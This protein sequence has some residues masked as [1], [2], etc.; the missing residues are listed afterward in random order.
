MNTHTALLDLMRGLPEYRQLVAEAQRDGPR[1]VSLYGVSHIHKAHI[2]ATLLADLGRPV[3]VITRDEQS[4]RRMAL[5]IEGF[6]G[7][8]VA[9]LPVR[10]FIFHN[11]DNVSREYEH[12]RIGALY[13]FGFGKTPVLTAPVEAMMLS[14]MPPDVMEKAVLRLCMDEDYDLNDLA[15]RLTEA[16]YTNTLTVEG[17]G[18]FALR[19]GILDVFPVGQEAPVRAEFFGDAVDSLGIFDPMTQRSCQNTECAVAPG[20]RRAAH[21]FAAG[22]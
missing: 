4:A 2:A 1:V 12:Q 17:P 19:G 22:R 14:T 20:G 21:H 5:D 8:K 11:I 6:C 3:C 7:Q 16:G 10:D 15:S 9:F 18:Q 13:S